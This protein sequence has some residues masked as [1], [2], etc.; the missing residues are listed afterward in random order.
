MVWNGAS[1]SGAAG[2]GKALAEGNRT[3]KILIGEVSAEGVRD[4]AAGNREAGT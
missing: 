2:S 3:G 4:I 1:R